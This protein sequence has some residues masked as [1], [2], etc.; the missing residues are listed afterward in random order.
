MQSLA[1]L[2][3]MASGLVLF[4]L[5]RRGAARGEDLQRAVKG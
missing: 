3:L 5:S 2:G 1:S 4:F